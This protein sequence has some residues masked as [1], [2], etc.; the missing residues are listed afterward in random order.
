MDKI[1][2]G[3]PCGHNCELYVNFLMGTIKK[4]VSNLDNIE[5]LLGIN[6]R[7][8]NRE[9]LTKNKNIFNIRVI[10]TIS[11]HHGSLGHGFCLDSILKHMDAKYGM[12]VD[13]DVAF[14]EKN[15]DEKLREHLKEDIVV[16]GADTD[17]KHNHY[18]NFP[19]TIMIM[20]LVEAIKKQNISFTPTHEHILIDEKNCHLFNE[21]SY[22]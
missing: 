8:V 3:I 19:F 21:N 5:F 4:T 15:W 10:E 6:K 18:K 2:I 20:F 22:R 17:P 1:Q 16:I 13:C 14:L 7:T 12:F 9:L 11:E